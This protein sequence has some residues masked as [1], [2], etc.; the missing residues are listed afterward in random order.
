MCRS[1]RR[2]QRLGLLVE[3]DGLVLVLSQQL[4]CAALLL[5]LGHGGQRRLLVRVELRHI[6]RRGAVLHGFAAGGV[7]A[8]VPRSPLPGSLWGGLARVSV[9]LVFFQYSASWV[10]RDALVVAVLSS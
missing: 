3:A 4:L 9:K 7:R 5:D 10:L 6:R 8:C 2:L 1:H